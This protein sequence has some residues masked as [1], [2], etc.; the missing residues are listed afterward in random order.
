MIINNKNP[1]LLI[2]TPLR[3]ND[4]ILQE[5]Y[6]SVSKTNISIHWIKYCDNKNPYKNFDTAL[7][8]Y[9]KNYSLPKYIIKMDNDI[10]VQPNMLEQMVKTLNNSLDQIAYTYC[11]FSFTG[12]INISFNAKEFDINHLLQSNYISSISMMKSEHLKKIGGVVTD[13]KYFRL[14]DWALWL[15]F[16]YHG[17]IGKPTL[18]TSFIAYASPNS[19]SAGSSK[20]YQKKLRYIINDFVI[21]IKKNKLNMIIQSH[22][23]S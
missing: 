6:D 19:V 21:P 9:E 3:I 23:T 16:L 14:L 17:K 12:S 11:D 2:I 18:N 13:D 4:N 8:L 7:T 20:D 15:K 22:L 10:I 1:E 5:T